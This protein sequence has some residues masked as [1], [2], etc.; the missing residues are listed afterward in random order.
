[1]PTYGDDSRRGFYLRNGGYYFAFNDYWDMRL[2]GEIYTKGSWGT[3][4]EST[5]NRRYR[6]SGNIF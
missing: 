6:Y 3:T 2:L 5:Y 1:M 4:I